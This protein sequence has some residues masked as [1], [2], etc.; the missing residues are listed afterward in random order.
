MSTPF[1]GVLSFSRQSFVLF[2]LSSTSVG[3]AA[4]P[5][6]RWG[7]WNSWVF[8]QHNFHL[9]ITVTWWTLWSPELWAH[10]HSAFGLVFPKVNILQDVNLF[11]QGNSKIANMYGAFTLAR[12]CF[13]HII[14]SS[15]T[16]ASFK[17]GITIIL[18]IDKKRKPREVKWL[19]QDHTAMR[20]QTL[21]LKSPDMTS[22]PDTWNPIRFP[23]LSPLKCTNYCSTPVFLEQG[24]EI[25][26]RSRRFEVSPCPLVSAWR[27]PRSSRHRTNIWIFIFLSPK[28]IVMW[29]FL[30]FLLLPD[31]VHWASI[32]RAGK[33]SL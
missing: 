12:H 14:C 6:F 19:S 32:P 27:K 26:S 23:A 11:L 16:L 8:V 33:K 30:V 20:W 29:P 13:K 21:D 7:I 10:T 15:F 28:I 2:W 9:Q 22:K 5:D 1:W 17:M 24:E 18:C 3:Y 31:P 4:E 25:S